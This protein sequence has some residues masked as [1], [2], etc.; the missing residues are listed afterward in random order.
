MSKTSG[1]AKVRHRLQH[2]EVKKILRRETVRRTVHPHPHL[3]RQVACPPACLA[4]V[5][6]ILASSRP[7]SPSCETDAIP[8]TP[9][10]ARSA[11]RDRDLCD[12]RRDVEWQIPASLEIRRGI[13]RSIGQWPHSGTWASGPSRR[14]APGVRKYASIEE[15]SRA[16][17]QWR[18]ENRRFHL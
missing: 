16:Q 2:A 6:L 8:K 11:A 4:D 13:R 1:I 9:P 17:K 15:M 12:V 14:F 3:Q 10:A 18:D 7:R 5:P